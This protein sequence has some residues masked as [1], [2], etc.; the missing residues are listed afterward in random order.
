VLSKNIT[1]RPEQIDDL[2]E[3]IQ[4]SISSLTDIDDII[5]RTEGDLRTAETLKDHADNAA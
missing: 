4:R 3:G 2:A 1:L 5:R